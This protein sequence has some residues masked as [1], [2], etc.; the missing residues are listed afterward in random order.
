MD[1]SLTGNNVLKDHSHP[2]GLCATSFSLDATGR[3]DDN[4]LRNLGVT[5]GGGKM[6][7]TILPTLPGNEANP[8]ARRKRVVPVVPLLCCCGLFLVVGM[9]AQ[10]RG[11]GRTGP[12]FTS[13][14]APGAG[15]QAG[16][17]T[18][19]AAINRAGTITGTY[20]DGRA[21][22]HSFVRASKGMITTFNA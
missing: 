8:R 19:P 16:R 21:V 1:Y 3:R 12:V 6:R 13:F 17:G 18:A 2:P 22:T 20:T 7:T 9:A 15:T 5:F 10:E 4:H 14:E 11:I